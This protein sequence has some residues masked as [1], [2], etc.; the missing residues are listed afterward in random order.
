MSAG[1]PTSVPHRTSA[2]GHEAVS[3]DSRVWSDSGVDVPGDRGHTVSFCKSAEAVALRRIAKGAAER[4]LA[5]EN[6]NPFETVH[7][8]LL[9]KGLKEPL[10]RLT[11]ARKMLSVPWGMW[12]NGQEYQ[13]ALVT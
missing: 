3:G 13:P 2:S 9:E 4:A 6:G 1:S 8:R 10:A 11:V 5:T 12:K 7:E